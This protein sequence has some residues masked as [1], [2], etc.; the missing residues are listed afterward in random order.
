MR[1]QRPPSP[2]LRRL[3]CLSLLAIPSPSRADEAENRERLRDMPLSRREDLL[4]NL[5]R[6]RALPGAERTAIR[7]LDRRIAEEDPTVRARHLSVLRRY[8]LWL[9][10]LTDAQ[11]TALQ[12]ASADEKLALLGD[13]LKAAPKVDTVPIRNESKIWTQ[14]S[15]LSPVLLIDQA[16]WIHIWLNLTPAQRE[17]VNRKG[18]AEAGRYRLLDQFARENSIADERPAIRREETEAV[19]QKIQSRPRL[20]KTYDQSKPAAKRAMTGR[21]NER[22]YLVQHLSSRV[23]HAH[24]DQFVK[25]LPPWMLNSVDSLPPDAAALRMRVLYRMLFPEGTEMTVA[26]PP[27]PAPKSPAAPPP[28]TTPGGVSAF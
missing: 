6:F 13:Y 4:K 18:L 23:D 14:L 15:S 27:K 2:L 12:N 24:L 1:T 7:D 10:T 9:A 19:L 3:L 25:A 21:L 11:R 28:P 8:H 22:R 17:Q 16:H 5:D 26:P 20:K